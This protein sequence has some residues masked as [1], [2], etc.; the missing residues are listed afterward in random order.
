[1]KVMVK[2]FGL[3]AEAAD[4]SEE[5]LE[6]NGALTASELK[7]QCLNGLAIADKDSVQIAVNQNLDNK[8]IIKD[9]D[10]VALLPPFAGG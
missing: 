10:E 6:L 7:A 4:K 5:V 8:I 2:Y 9:G 3:V 1:M